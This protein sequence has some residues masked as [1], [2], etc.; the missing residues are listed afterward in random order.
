MQKDIGKFQY[1]SLNG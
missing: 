1:I